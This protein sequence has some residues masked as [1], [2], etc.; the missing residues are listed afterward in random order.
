MPRRV[1]DSFRQWRY[2]FED[3]AV[4]VLEMRF[5][6]CLANAAIGTM[7]EMG[8]NVGLVETKGEMPYEEIERANQMFEESRSE[9]LEMSKR[10]IARKIEQGRKA[11]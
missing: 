1:S 4:S 3:V 5:L 2:F 8:Y 6:M 9:A 7:F 11:K 10:H